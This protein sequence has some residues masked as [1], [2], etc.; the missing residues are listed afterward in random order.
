MQGKNKWWTIQF[1]PHGKGNIQSYKIKF[2][3]IIFT[4]NIIVLITLLGVGASLFLWNTTKELDVRLDEQQLELTEYIEENH[5]LKLRL[6]HVNLELHDLHNNLMDLQHYIEEVQQL[7]QQIKQLDDDSTSYRSFDG[8]VQ[9]TEQNLKISG[10][11]VSAPELQEAAFLAVDTQ[12]VDHV[13]TTLHRPEATFLKR[14]NP[15][16]EATLSMDTEALRAQI[17]ALMAQAQSQQNQLSDLKDYIEEEQYKALFI[18]SIA[19]SNGKITSHFGYRK[20][21]FHGSSRMHKGIDFSSSNRSPVY[22]TAQG[23]VTFAGR[24]GNYGKQVVIDHGNGYETSYAHLASYSVEAGD[25]VEKGSEI[26]K[27]G[28]TGR[29]TGV[30]LHYEVHK[31]G[32]AIDPYPYI[33]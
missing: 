23:T 2:L 4:V 14:G 28:S 24:N 29:S 8:L 22:A 10:I 33:K 31:N 11:H 25:E 13:A 12:A 26:G 15:S 7:E 9:R 3:P 17:T 1:I 32:E 16:T 5:E 20:D 30:H 19:P 6:S 21:P 18:P 27:M